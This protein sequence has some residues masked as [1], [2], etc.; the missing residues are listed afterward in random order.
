MIN[1]QLSLTLLNGELGSDTQEHTDTTQY[2][3]HMDTR[4]EK[5]PQEHR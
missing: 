4:D 5:Y 3:H 1:H 2:C